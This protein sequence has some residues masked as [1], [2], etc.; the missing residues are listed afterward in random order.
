[1]PA[2]SYRLPAYVCQHCSGQSMLRPYTARPSLILPAMPPATSSARRAETAPPPPPPSSIPA[3]D[4]APPRTSLARRYVSRY[5]L[6]LC[7]LS[8]IAALGA[9][10]YARLHGGAFG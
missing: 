3:H 10:S 7:A 6:A 1:M 9:W 8:W 2:D 4:A 5:A